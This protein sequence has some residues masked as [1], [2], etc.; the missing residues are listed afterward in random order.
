MERVEPWDEHN[1]ALVEQVRPAS[2]QNPVPQGRYNLVAIGGGT[3][4]LV[5]A[6]GAAALG[7]RVAL[8]E[9]HLLGGDCLNYGCVPSKAL[10]RSARAC[11]DAKMAHLLGCRTG[12]A[13]P[14]FPSIMQRMRRLRAG[15]ARHDAAE[16][17]RSLGIDV[18][19]GTARFCERQALEV[20]G[21]RLEFHRAVIA[22]GSRPLIPALDGLEQTAYLTS[23]S[24][25]S[26]ERL[27]GSLIVLGGGPIGCELG[28][29]F[30]RF[31][32]QVHL[33]S[34]GDRLLRREEPEASSLLEA[35]LARE[36][37]HL[38]LG[39]QAVCVERMGSAYSLTIERAGTRQKLVAEAMLVAVGRRANVEG[40]DCERAGVVCDE[41]GVRVNERL[42]TT[43]RAVYAAGDVCSE[44]K[45]THAA[46]AMAR[47]CVQNA[48][49]LGR[50]SVNALLIPRCTYTDP[51]VAQVG[52]TAARARQLGVRLDTFC[53]TLDHVDRALLDGEAEGL[54]MLHVLRG[55]DRIVGATLVARHAG[56]MI[57]EIS[58]AI[59]RRVGLNA[60]SHVIHCYPTQAEVWKRLGD[61]YQRTR[62]TPRLTRLARAWLAWLRR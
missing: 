18:Y 48:L 28:Q 54:A 36:G 44:Y 11:H 16:R 26:L 40:L 42:Q 60:F 34:R 29:A 57:G 55:T 58:L 13:E 59:A 7:G 43:N 9:R 41:Q 53:E 38:Y 2:W 27:P 32:C 14:D 20:A 3:A 17:L 33:V 56:E 35:Q 12:Q 24:I 47:I 21:Q 49:F 4:G 50:R 31:G 62:L 15:I 8:V 52:L 51:E 30:R 1:R 23:E 5:A 22:T 10:L 45:F 37:V 6:V 46:D 61:Q 25:F 39:W 19:F